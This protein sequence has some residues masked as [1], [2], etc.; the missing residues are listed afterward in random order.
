MN[1]I[2]LIIHFFKFL[3]VIIAGFMVGYWFYKFR[4]DE[5][6]SV[7]EYKPFK[8]AE[9][10]LYPELNFC[11]FNPFLNN[12]LDNISGGLNRTMYIEYLNG[13]I[14]ANETYEKI[15]FEAVTLNFFDYLEN[16]RL[17]WKDKSIPSTHCKAKPDCPYLSFRNT[18]NG[19]IGEGKQFFKC[20]GITTNRMYSHSISA[21]MLRMADSIKELLNEDIST[22]LLLHYPGQKFRNLLYF[23][24]WGDT[25]ERKGGETNFIIINS[26]EVVKRRNKRNQ[27]CIPHLKNYDDIITRQEIEKVGCR[28]PYHLS[29]NQLP[30]CRKPED[31]KT[32]QYMY[33]KLADNQIPPCHEMSHIGY[34]HYKEVKKKR[35]F[36]FLL[37]YPKYIKEI[38]Q[39]QKIDHHALIGNIGGYI[40]LFLGI[41]LWI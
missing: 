24:F 25:K 1:T 20:F 10:T 16:I 4:K 40:G 31:L 41:L 21:I 29:N 34:K 30:I 37:N 9:N 35:M 6:I 39:E 26:F 18:Y 27:R 8:D 5:D 3:C 36:I 23:N 38:S 32:F 19:F 12:K 13:N 28:A 11:L 2:D 22:A 7:I 15:S 17:D 14:P 33:S